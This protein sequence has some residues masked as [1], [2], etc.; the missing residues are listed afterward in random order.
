MIRARCIERLPGG[1]RR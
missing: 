1:R